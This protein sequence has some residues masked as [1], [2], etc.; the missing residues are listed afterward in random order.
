[1]IIADIEPEVHGFAVDRVDELG[2]GAGFAMELIVRF[3]SSSWRIGI[4][5]EVGHLA[6]AEAA[7][8]EGKDGVWHARIGAARSEIYAARI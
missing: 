7:F 4:G 5:L 8:G 1:M 3:F 6:L 2:G